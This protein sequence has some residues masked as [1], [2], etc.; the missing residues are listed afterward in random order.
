MPTSPAKPRRSVLFKV[1]VPSSKGYRSPIEDLPDK[2]HPESLPR[3]DLRHHLQKK[4]GAPLY[5]APRLGD[6]K[7]VRESK[8]SVKISYKELDL[9]NNF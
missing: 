8:R 3:T 6:D 2:K 1:T 5:H 4:A 9:V 7:P